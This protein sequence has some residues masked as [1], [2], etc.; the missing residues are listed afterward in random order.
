MAFRQLI[1]KLVCEA[2]ENGSLPR[3]RLHSTEYPANLSEI[4]TPT[5]LPL[6]AD[7]SAIYPLARAGLG[8]ILGHDKLCVF[9]QFASML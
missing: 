9:I 4:A 7:G 8:L 2:G 3:P 1:F 5:V 6:A